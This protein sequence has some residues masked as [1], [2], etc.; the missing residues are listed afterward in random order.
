MEGLLQADIIA[1]YHRLAQNNVIYVSGTDCHGT[2]ITLRAAKEGRSPQ[3]ISDFYHNEFAK[4]FQNMDFSYDLYSKT[5]S[6]FHKEQVKK[7]FTTIKE[8]GYIFEKVQDQDYCPKCDKFLSDREIVGTCPHCGHEAKGDQ[9]DYCLTSIE[10]ATLTDK[11]CAICGTKTIMKQNKHLFF[12]LTAFQEV[13]QEYVNSHKNDW[14]TNAYN[15]SLKY[16]EMGLVDRAATR[17]LSWGIDTPVEGYDDKKIYVWI[18]AVLGYLTTGMQ[19]ANQKGIDFDTFLTDHEELTSY[20]VHGKDNIPFHT[21]IFPALLQAIN[22]KWQLPKKI[23]SSEYI[24][25]NDEKMSKSK[26]NL[27]TVNELLEQFEKDTIRFYFI[28]NNPERKDSN[29]S[30]SEMVQH[31]NK[32]LVGVIG[33]F[34]N[35]NVSYIN[36]KYEGVFK[37]GVVDSEVKDYTLETYLEVAKLLEDGETRSALTRV[38]E[39]ASFANK[40]YDTK[41]P[42]VL[43]HENPVEFTNVSYT[44]AYIICNFA[45]LLAPFVPETANKIASVFGTDLDDGWKPVTIAGDLKVQNLSLLFSRIDDK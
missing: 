39:Y 16:L 10:P 9:C 7:F 44:C 40:Y 24:N 2:P 1:R 18:E 28:Y 37:E 29:F 15:E 17:Q 6:E 12:K 27:I 26:G 25:Q 31:H 42:W 30:L 43:A 11:H 14:R 35:R 36:K 22:T 32:F 4:T 20:Y 23:I 41:Q 38:V 3:E 5:S 13:L 21:I 33:N 45:K 8:H 34:I 19:V